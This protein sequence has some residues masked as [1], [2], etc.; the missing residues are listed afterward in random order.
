[1]EKNRRLTS[2]DGVTDTDLNKEIAWDGRRSASK[3][4]DPKD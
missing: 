4:Y 3:E 1:L 2:D